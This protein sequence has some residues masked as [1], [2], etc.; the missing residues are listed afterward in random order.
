MSGLDWPPSD[1]FG[2][3]TDSEL[4]AHAVDVRET[5][6][7]ALDGSGQDIERARLCELRRE[8][9]RDVLKA[10]LANRRRGL[11]TDPQLDDLDADLAKVVYGDRAETPTL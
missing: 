7:D 6:R 2:A 10:R 3:M 5:K 8:H 9:I 1:E 11:D 4:L